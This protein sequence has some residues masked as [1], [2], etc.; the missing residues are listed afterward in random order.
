[1]NRVT[2]MTS[3]DGT[4]DYT[5]DKLSRLTAVDF[6]YQADESYSYDANGNRNGG[7]NTISTNNRLTSD[8][9][10]NY[11]Y[12]DEGN[13]T[14]RTKI[15]DSSYREF[16]WD[17]RNR[18]TQVQ[19]KNSS[20]TVLTDFDYTYD[21]FDKLIK[22]S[23][24]NDGPGAGTAVVARYVY[25]GNLPA[26]TFDGSNVLQDRYLSAPMIDQ[27]MADENGAGAILTPLTDLQGSVTDLLNTSGASQ[28]HIAYSAFGAILSETG[29]SVDFI[30]GFDNLMGNEETATWSSVGNIYTPAAG[31]WN[32]PSGG[33]IS[34]YMFA[35]NS[36]ANSTQQAPDARPTPVNAIGPIYEPPIPLPLPYMPPPK[37]APLHAGSAHNNISLWHPSQQDVVRAEVL[38]GNQAAVNMVQASASMLPPTSI[39]MNSMMVVGGQDLGGRQLT[40]NERELA[41]AGLF[42]DVVTIF[43]GPLLGQLDEAATAATMSA[44]SLDVAA[45]ARRTGDK[46]DQ[47]VVAARCDRSCFVAGT[48]VAIYRDE[49]STVLGES[50]DGAHNSAE[51]VSEGSARS[52]FLLAGAVAVFIVTVAGW[53]ATRRQPR[54]SE[55]EISDEA[56]AQWL[57]E[58]D[59]SLA[60][61]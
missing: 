35:G 6:S 53:A 29:P 41:G 7:S 44:K 37:E 58:N 4:A 25:D 52:M 38:A 23:V 61:H 9:T 11:T 12:D 51:T 43:L 16:T 8:G 57:C 22:R 39:A 3:Q 30:C 28:N 10:Y 50:D 56:L 33:L 60:M 54:R 36:P 59:I 17:Y 24:D 46:L 34:P 47:A 21:L 26:F 20:N 15:S 19:D 27:I 45:D 1:M 32:S 49:Q 55:Q 2:Q 31:I 13:L 14:R 42:I 5:Y 18:L 40:Q 48:L